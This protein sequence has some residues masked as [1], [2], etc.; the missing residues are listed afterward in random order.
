MPIVRH[1]VDRGVLR[2]R[3]HHHAIDELQVAQLERQEHRRAAA[4]GDAR[5][6]CQAPLDIADECSVAQLEIVVTDALTS[7]Q[8]AVRE[9]QRLE[10]RVTRDVFEPLH[11]IARG[12]L[13]FQRFELA[14]LLVALQ[15]ATHITAAC[16]LAAQC[17]R[18][19]HREL[20]ARAD[21]EVRGVRGVA[22]QN[23]VAREP[24]ATQH[25]IEIEP[26]RAAQ[27]P[28]VTH[29]SRA[30]EILPEQLLGECD[31]LVGRR[32]VQAVRAPGFLACLHDHRR[33]LGAELIGV[34]LEPAVLRP[35]ERKR[36]CGEA[37]GR[38]EPDIAAFAHVDI[39]LEG[40]R[41]LLAHSAV[42]AVGGDQQIG[43]RELGLLANFV[44]ERLLD[45]EARGA[46]LQNVEQTLALDTREAMAT[47]A[48][49]SAV[50]VHI[51]V[52][53]VI[54]AVDDGGVRRRIGGSEARHGLVR[55]H[56]APTEGV[57]RA[58]ALVDLDARARQ[59]LLQQ[60]R[61]IQARR[62]AAHAD[63]A[64]H[65]RNFRYG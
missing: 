25:A 12:A 47:G 49:R 62:P 61:R 59:R 32:G 55:E 51:D 42:A 65:G 57:V 15:P 58:I 30:A 24:A 21:R 28:R 40:R 11:A 44:L 35:L 7:R 13:Q 38:A 60:D 45:A 19:L 14:L 64:L 46:L 63:D 33:K 36:E 23:D 5:S 31:G 20:R 43:I 48:D 26:R 37:L 41:V 18:I 39:G 56:H 8:Q 3:R 29:E 52:V 22:D 6:L 9:L 10:M 17:N 4:I 54:E 1:A 50:D 34:D 27:V 16:D 2:H 53:P